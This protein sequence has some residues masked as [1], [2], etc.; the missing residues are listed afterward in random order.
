MCMDASALWCAEAALALTIRDSKD[1]AW[2]L[3][4]EWVLSIHAPKTSTW[5]LTREWALARDTTVHTFGG[6]I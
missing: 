6:S 2:V 3:T 1:L 4:R 5:A